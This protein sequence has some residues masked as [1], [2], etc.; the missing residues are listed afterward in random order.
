[1][2]TDFLNEKT[3]QL[4]VKAADREDAIRKAAAC[5]VEE[6]KIKQDYIEQMIEALHK[7]GPYIVVIPGIALAHAEAGSTV[8]E[9]CMSMMTLKEPIAFGHESNDPVSVVFV[10]AS[11]TKDKH[12]EVLMDMSKLLMK[13]EFIQLLNESEDVNGILNYFKIKE[14]KK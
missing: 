12:L 9:E 1:M 3:I 8:M 2:I 4:K 6:K 10:I 5:L 14:E 13:K 11:N 7:F